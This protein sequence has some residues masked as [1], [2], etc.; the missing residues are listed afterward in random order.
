M[1]LLFQIP[2]VACCAAMKMLEL[3]KQTKTLK[4]REDPASSVTVISVFL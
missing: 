3:K 4:V 1:Q 2:V